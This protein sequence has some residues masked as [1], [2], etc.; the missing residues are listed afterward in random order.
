LTDNTA[1]ITAVL[2]AVLQLFV[3]GAF[4]A[5]VAPPPPAARWTVA[6]ATAGI[7]MAVVSLTVLLGH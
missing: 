6:A 5:R 4:V 2:V 7:G 1:R 3:I